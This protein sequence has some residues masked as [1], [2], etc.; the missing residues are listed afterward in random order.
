VPTTGPNLVRAGE[1]PPVM[2]LAATKHTQA[3]AVAF[4]KFFM[5][6]IDWGFATT[7]GSYIRHYYASSCV[8]CANHAD[9]LD[10]TR[11]AGEFYVGGRFTLTDARAAAV[12]DH[13]ADQSAVVTFDLTSV[14]M[15]DTQ[16]RFINADVAHSGLREQIWLSWRSSHWIVVE[17]APA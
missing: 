5:R 6:T 2:P 16:D 3:G 4:A 12:G 7:S 11:K 14:E 1:R 8:E 15:L 17:S 13:H 9:S 10:A